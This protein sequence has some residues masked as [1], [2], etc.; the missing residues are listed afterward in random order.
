MVW[1]HLEKNTGI[2]EEL[3][4]VNSELDMQTNLIFSLLGLAQVGE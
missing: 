2:T 3:P 1:E 4:R